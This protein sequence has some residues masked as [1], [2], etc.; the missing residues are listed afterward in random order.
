MPGSNTSSNTHSKLACNRLQVLRQCGNQV[1]I[2]TRRRHRRQPFATL[3]CVFILP[4][5][6]IFRIKLL[7]QFPHTAKL[8]YYRI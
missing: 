2:M 4:D 8:T 1:A 5:F 6:H 7:G 3:F